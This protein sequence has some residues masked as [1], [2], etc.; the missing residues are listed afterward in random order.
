[1]ALR[2][3]R[4]IHKLMKP[5]MVTVSQFIEDG[6]EKSQATVCYDIANEIWIR[7]NTLESDSKKPASKRMNKTMRDRYQVELTGLKTAL[8]LA[9]GLTYMHMEV[10]ID[11]FLNRFQQERLAASREGNS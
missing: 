3:A 1:M 9:L 5:G 11:A 10:N 6:Q 2:G 8:R 7:I 4:G